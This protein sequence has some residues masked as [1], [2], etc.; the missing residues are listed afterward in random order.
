[1]SLVESP[2]KNVTAGVMQDY[3][4]GDERR[5]MLEG[6]LPDMVSGMPWDPKFCAWRPFLSTYLSSGCNPELTRKYYFQIETAPRCLSVPGNSK[7][8]FFDSVCRLLSGS[9]GKIFVN[10]DYAEVVNFCETVCKFFITQSK[11]FTSNLHSTKMHRS[12]LAGLL[13]MQSWES[14][15]CALTLYRHPQVESDDLWTPQLIMKLQARL[16]DWLQSFL[17]SFDRVTKFVAENNGKYSWYCDT[18]RSILQR[19][20]S[21]ALLMENRPDPLGSKEVWNIPIDVSDT[22][23][24]TVVKSPAWYDEPYDRQATFDALTNVFFPDDSKDP[25]YL[26]KA[27]FGICAPKGKI[28]RVADTL[29][30]FYWVVKDQKLTYMLYNRRAVEYRQGIGLSEPPDTYLDSLYIRGFPELKE[31]GS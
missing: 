27:F 23:V 14:L 20:W 10:T 11:N 12:T 17:E 28:K 5:K 26:C 18:V 22:L 4:L 19:T 6:I 1:M 16:G 29:Y 31:G 9:D 7:S 8:E 30:G 2:T 24:D 25:N 13:E 21:T 3:V 15:M